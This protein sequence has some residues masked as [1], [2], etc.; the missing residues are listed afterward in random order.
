MRIVDGADEVV[1]PFLNKVTDASKEILKRY[2]R[3]AVRAYQL[4]Q[5][6]EEKKT[7]PDPNAEA[8]LREEGIFD[9]FRPVKDIAL[10][11]MAD[12]GLPEGA[13]M[14][15]DLLTP[16]GL[17]IPTRGSFK[18]KK[19]NYYEY[20]GG[21]NSIGLSTVPKRKPD[22]TRTT[23]F[24]AKKYKHRVYINEDGGVRHFI[25]DGDKPITSIS[26]QLGKYEGDNGTADGICSFSL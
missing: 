19:S 2:P 25:F 16:D 7:E 23:S 14:A 15:F 3:A 10:T 13:Q 8:G 21:R 4:Y 20:S 17:P 22:M 26:G 1:R 12:S 24:N 11:K 18:P 6:E 9:I 5:N